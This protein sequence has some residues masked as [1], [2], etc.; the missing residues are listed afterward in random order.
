MSLGANATPAATATAAWETIVGSGF[1]F[2]GGGVK[3][4]ISKTITRTSFTGTRQVEEGV[5]V[6]EKEFKD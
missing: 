3:G 6:G 4:L 5:G 2:Y 1:S